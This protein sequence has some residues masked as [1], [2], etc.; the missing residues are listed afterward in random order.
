MGHLGSKLRDHLQEGEAAG[1][2]H[3]GRLAR[4]ILELVKPQ[5]ALAGLASG[6]DW[7][8]PR[9]ARASHCSR[10]QTSGMKATRRGY[11]SCSGACGATWRLLSA[12]TARPRACA[13]TP[14]AD[15][16]E[17]L[18]QCGVGRDVHDLRL[19]WPQSMRSFDIVSPSGRRCEASTPRITE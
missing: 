11:P 16:A 17:H 15:F 13:A 12:R 7:R 14:S 10:A 4:A 19:A 8:A 5:C 3:L 18:A 2:V 1:R 9:R 6:D